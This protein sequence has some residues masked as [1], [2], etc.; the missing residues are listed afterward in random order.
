MAYNYPFYTR[1]EDDTYGPTNKGHFYLPLSYHNRTARKRADKNRWRIKPPEQYEV[2]RVAD[3]NSEY[4]QGDGGLYGF[5][6]KMDEVLG[7][8]NE[9]R[10]AYFPDPGN[11]PWHGYP[12]SSKE[13]SNEVIKRWK[14]TAFISTRNYRNLLKREI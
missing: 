14:D 5:L 3:D 1:N 8:D 9:E 4:Y 2:F 12:V 10:I 13:I 7:L 11:D 6:D